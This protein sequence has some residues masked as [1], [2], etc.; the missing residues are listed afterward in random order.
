MMETNII[1]K[2]QPV[3]YYTTL[4]NSITSKTKET[5]NRYF[6]DEIVIR[7]DRCTN[8]RL[9]IRQY[10]SK[11]LIVEVCRLTG[12]HHRELKEIYY[13]ENGKMV[14]RDNKY[15]ISMSYSQNFI[16]CYLGMVKV[17]VDMEVM[18]ELPLTNKISVLQ[19]LTDETVKG[20]LDFYTLWTKIESIV[21]FYDNIDMYKVLQDKMWKSTS[22]AIGRYINNNLIFSIATEKIEKIKIIK[23]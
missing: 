9:K 15:F 19:N 20:K 4:N 11:E 22:L 16:A 1:N 14:F 10:L 21:K 6:S 2:E 17:G 8:P 7:M 23:L 18:G 5:V 12:I 3:I 13:A